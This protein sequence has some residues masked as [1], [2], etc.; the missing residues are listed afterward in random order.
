MFVIPETGLKNIQHKMQKY[1]ILASTTVQELENNGRRQ[2]GMTTQYSSH[3]FRG[4]LY[5]KL[6]TEFRSLS[7]AGLSATCVSKLKLYTTA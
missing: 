6:I 5:R 4:E 1:I 2:T 3:C 7:V